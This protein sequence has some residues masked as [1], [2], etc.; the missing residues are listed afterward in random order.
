MHP[1]QEH[2]MSTEC[3]AVYYA[4]TAQAFIAGIKC[5]HCTLSCLALRKGGASCYAGF[6]HELVEYTKGQT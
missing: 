6:Q 4:R 5:R 3:A 2:W 1:C